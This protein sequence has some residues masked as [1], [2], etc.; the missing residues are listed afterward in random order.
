MPTH[1]ETE[2]KKTRCCGALPCGEWRSKEG[3]RFCIGRECMAWRWLVSPELAEFDR[4]T[5]PNNPATELHGF[6]G[7]AGKL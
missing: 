1:T 7:L 4:R 5:N 3:A 2:A 6:C